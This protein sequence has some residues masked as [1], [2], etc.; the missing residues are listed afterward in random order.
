MGRFCTGAPFT[1]STESFFKFILTSR[2]SGFM[3]LWT[4]W[5]L[6]KYL[7]AL[8]RLKSIEL[9][10]RSVYLLE[11]MITSKR[12]PPWRKSVMSCNWE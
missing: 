7:I 4:M 1:G 9:A 6:C 8:A 3:S 11:E 5:R 2:F 12:L 10:S